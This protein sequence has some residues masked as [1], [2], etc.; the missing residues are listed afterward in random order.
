MRFTIKDNDLRFFEART[1]QP[2]AK[3]FHESILFERQVSLVTVTVR[4]TDNDV[5]CCILTAA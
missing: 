4:A 2:F 1:H 3:C 5:L